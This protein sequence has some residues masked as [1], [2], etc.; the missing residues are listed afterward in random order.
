MVTERQSV[1]LCIGPTMQRYQR[2]TCQTTLMR[3][4]RGRSPAWSEGVAGPALGGS[5]LGEGG[6]QNR[7]SNRELV[8]SARASPLNPPD[9]DFNFSAEYLGGY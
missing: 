7:G 5:L 9:P 1:L 2:L 3:C 6:G 8:T 4:E